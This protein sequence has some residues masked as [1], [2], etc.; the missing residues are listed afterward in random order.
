MTRTAL[1]VGDMQ[2]GITSNFAFAELVVP[3]IAHTLSQVR[4]RDIS[5]IYLR[6]ALRT[7]TDDIGGGNHLFAAFHGAGPLFREDS[8]LTEVD[9]RLAPQSHDSVVLKRRTSGFAHTDLDLILRARQV[10]SIALCGVATSAMV[11]ATVYAASDHD[12][13]ITVLRDLCAD[14]S[15]A[16]HDLLCDQIFP[17]RGV[18]VVTAQTW[19]SGLPTADQVDP[20]Q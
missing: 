1:I 5:V 9:S 20:Q 10:S 12:Y 18:D 3:R 6:A 4:T 13:A 14:E 11:A 19:L 7:S 16:M 17:A 15:A 8:P 2:T